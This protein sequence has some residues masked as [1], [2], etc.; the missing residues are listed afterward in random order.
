M[1]LELATSPLS[2]LIGLEVRLFWTW[3]TSLLCCGSSTAWKPICSETSDLFGNVS[4]SVFFFFFFLHYTYTCK[5]C[6]TYY[7]QV[8]TELVQ[9]NFAI[10]KQ[11]PCVVGKRIL[12]WSLCSQ[13]SYR[14]KHVL[15]AF[16]PF[17]SI[18]P[19]IEIALLNLECCVERCLQSSK[20]N[21]KIL[22]PFNWKK[23]HPVKPLGFGNSKREAE[24]GY[25]WG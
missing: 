23:C 4:F 13:S 9:N 7:L 16:F 5:I 10:R 1:V 19:T 20:N 17:F 24:L 21:I 15:F 6:A 8:I 22:E 25:L 2:A 18:Q 11:L 14:V 3:I 12:P